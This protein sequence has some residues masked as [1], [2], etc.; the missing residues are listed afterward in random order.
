MR[1]G[2]R[3]EQQGQGQRGEGRGLLQ[4]PQ[5]HGQR[6]DDQGQREDQ[7]RIPLEQVGIQEPGQDPQQQPAR[8]PGH[9]QQPAG[10]QHQADEREGQHDAPGPLDVMQARELVREP[11]KAAQGRGKRQALEGV[12]VQRQ[13]LPVVQ[14]RRHAQVRHVRGHRQEVDGP[15]RPHRQGYQQ[16]QQRSEGE[17][18]AVGRWHRGCASV[19]QC[20]RGLKW[21]RDPDPPLLAHLCVVASESALDVRE[22][23]FAPIPRSALI[24]I[25]N[26]RPVKTL[27]V[28]S[29]ESRESR[30]RAHSPRN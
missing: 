20:A 7:R 16:G 24:C 5:V 30:G 25:Q 29:G 12:A 26:R 6:R 23:A 10:R 28:D 27:P 18:V 11:G 1:H 19:R 2:Q 13:G 4:Q 17:V 14:D 15:Q 3:G 8:M 9:C 22:Y 21:R